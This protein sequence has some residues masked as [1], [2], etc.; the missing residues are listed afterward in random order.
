MLLTFLPRQNLWVTGV[1][2]VKGMRPEGRQELPAGTLAG[3]GEI[4]DG[5][6]G[7]ASPITDDRS[8]M[9]RLSPCSCQ[10]TAFRD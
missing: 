4:G 8:P 6:Q 3:R 7:N 5:C 2:K 9:P 10:S 1:H